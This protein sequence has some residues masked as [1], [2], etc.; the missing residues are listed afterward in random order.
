MKMLCDNCLH[1]PVCG[2]FRATGGQVQ[3]CDYLLEQ[4]YG[5]WV[6]LEAEIGYFACSE[7]DHRILR[8]KCNY[9][10]DCGSIMDL[11]R[12]TDQTMAAL[13]KMGA[14]AHGEREITS[15]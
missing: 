2:K 13:E 15:E 12:I 7:C 8:A 5:R 1:K 6:C 3:K 4:K 9:C 14:Q 11:P 10:P